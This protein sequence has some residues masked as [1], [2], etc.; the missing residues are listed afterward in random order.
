MNFHRLRQVRDILRVRVQFRRKVCSELNDNHTS[1]GYVAIE[2][3]SGEYFLNAD[4]EI[5]QKEARAKHPGRLICT[6]QLTG[7]S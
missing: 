5:A 4:K 7:V 6:F 3:E 1:S 2:P